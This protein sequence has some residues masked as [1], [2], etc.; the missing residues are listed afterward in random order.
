MKGLVDQF[1][2]LKAA[3]Q[4]VGPK[5]AFDANPE[6]NRYRDVYCIDATRVVLSDGA[7]GDYIHANWVGVEGDKQRFI[8]TQVC[9]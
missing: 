6:K 4:G 3:T 7:P 1:N 8:C 9:K 5:V 2:Q